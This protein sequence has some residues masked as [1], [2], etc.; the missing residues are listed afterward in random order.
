MMYHITVLV[1]AL[2]CRWTWWLVPLPFTVAIFVYDEI[3]K[4]LLRKHPG[5]WIERETYY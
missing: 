5:G 2:V 3:R 1:I 4:Y